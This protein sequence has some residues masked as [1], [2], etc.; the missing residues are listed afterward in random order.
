MRLGRRQGAPGRGG[1][2]TIAENL[3]S[4]P[5]REMRP[6]V[7]PLDLTA[8]ALA[9]DVASQIPA[10]T[11]ISPTTRLR[12][13]GSP[14]SWVASNPAAIGLTVMVLA[15]RVGLARSSAITQRMNASAPPPTPR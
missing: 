8:F 1:T 7:A 10:N 9:S 5:S 13:I 2:A 3:L 12:V 14:T 6:H 15:T 11:A 4:L